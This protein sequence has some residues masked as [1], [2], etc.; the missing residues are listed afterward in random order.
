M[1]IFF[2]VYDIKISTL[3]GMFEWFNEMVFKNENRSDPKL[4]TNSENSHSDN[5]HSSLF[6]N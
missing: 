1:D 3:T 2:K 6:G 5:P 4:P